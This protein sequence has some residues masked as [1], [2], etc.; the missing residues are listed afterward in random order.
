MPYSVSMDC[1][2]P[3]PAQC[4]IMVTLDTTLEHDIKDIKMCLLNGPKIWVKHVISL[5]WL[6]EMYYDLIRSD[7]SITSSKGPDRWYLPKRSSI[8]GKFA[9]LLIG[10]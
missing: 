6:E 5:V 1:L 7:A 4:A 9:L 8:Q 2:V 10:Q 3:I